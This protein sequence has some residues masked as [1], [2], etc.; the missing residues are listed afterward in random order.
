M[1]GQGGAGGA[2]V[3]ISGANLLPSL[4]QKFRTHTAGG[5]GGDPGAGGPGGDGGPGGAGGQEAKPHCDGG[6]AGQAGG[7][8]PSGGPGQTG[9]NGT[10]RDLM[11][12]GITDKQFQDYV[13]S[14]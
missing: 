4:T 3:L 9:P 1:G 2:V 8:G 5:R 6:N 11:V 7:P 12:G 14:K 13:W 10:E